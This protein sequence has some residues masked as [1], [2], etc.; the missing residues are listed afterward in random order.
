M[1]AR[2]YAATAVAALLVSAVAPGPAAF[3]SDEQWWHT[4]WR[5]EEVWSITDGTGA[6]VAVIDSGVDASVPELAGSVLP[7][8][9]FF[10]PAGDAR[11]EYGDGHGTR[12]AAFIAADGGA[13]GIRGVAPGATVLPVALDIKGEAVAEQ[14]RDFDVLIGDFVEAIRWAVDEGAD[15][16]NMSF[17]LVTRRCP[18]ELAAATRYAFEQGVLLV[19]GAG[20]YQDS[21]AD[22]PANCPGVLAIGAS[23]SQLE[24]WENT[25]RGD[26]IHLA[27]PGVRMLTVGPGGEA[28]TSSGTSVSTALVSGVVA[29][30]RAQSPDASAEE[31]LSR[32]FATARDIHTPGW[33]EATGHGLVRP[34]QALTEPLPSQVPQPVV[35]LLAAV[36]VAPEATGAPGPLVTP[37]GVP[38]AGSGQG[39]GVPAWLA[40]VLAFAA[41]ALLV[42][43]AALLWAVRTRRT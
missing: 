22:I 42:L 1:R 41:V 2:H 33:D 12:M 14:L 18:E 16:I 40:G 11:V 24:P 7:G 27:A 32:L 5:M 36:A 37:V 31:V 26:F 6:T 4:Q 21:G 10:D 25:A 8:L 19:A 23:D 30:L 43:V 29:L 35:E 15:V 20:N 34:Y 9:D 3:A 39:G 28:W 13:G 17:V 38:E